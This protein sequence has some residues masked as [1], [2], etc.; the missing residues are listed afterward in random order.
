MLDFDRVAVER[1]RAAATASRAAVAVASDVAKDAARLDAAAASARDSAATVLASLPADA[2]S[3][4]RLLTSD[5]RTDR[6]AGPG[7]ASLAAVAY[8]R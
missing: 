4:W 2:A 8:A 3:G 7:T 6:T 5:G 1:R